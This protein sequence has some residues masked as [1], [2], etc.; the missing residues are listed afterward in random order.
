MR[1]G[2][3]SKESVVR[4]LLEHPSYVVTVPERILREPAQ[5]RK[6][7]SERIWKWMCTGG[8]KITSTWNKAQVQKV[9][10]SIWETRRQLV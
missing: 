5:Y 10:E 8:G 2:R 3:T 9:K 7:L 1:Y 6:R 4:I